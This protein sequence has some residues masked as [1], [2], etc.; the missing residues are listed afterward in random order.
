VIRDFPFASGETLPELRLHYTV[1]GTPRHD[2][3]G[4][5]NNALLVLHPTTVSGR[6]FLEDRF[7]GVLFGPGQLLDARRFVIILPDGI[8]HGKSSK[9][10]DG[11]RT[12]FPSY[13][14]ADMITAQYALVT[15]ALSINHLRLAL[16]TSMGG[17]QTFMWGETY[18]TSWT[19]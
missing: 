18:R 5:V 4:R 8:R 19:R 13:D 1:L 2:G 3:H 9:P 11:L 12:R 17:M 10:S 7:A 14:Y 6:T 16:G 15:G